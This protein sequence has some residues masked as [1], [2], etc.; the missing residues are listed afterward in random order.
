[1]E[2]AEPLELAE[3]FRRVLEKATVQPDIWR[4]GPQESTLANAV[5]LPSLSK[6]SVL[7][8][9]ALLSALTAEETTAILGHE[10]A[11]LED[12]ATRPLSMRLTTPALVLFATIVLPR[13]PYI[14][15]ELVAGAWPLL[16]LLVMWFR[17]HVRQERETKSDR[18]ALELAGDAEAL[19]SALTK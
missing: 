5:A 10:M 19:A 3:G 8:S 18:R 9:N 1:L 17:S 16:L 11:H 6:P 12:F 15:Q 13:L 7:F 2:F 4:A 14:P